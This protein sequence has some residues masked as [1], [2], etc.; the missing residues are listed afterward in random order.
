MFLDNFSR[1][2]RSPSLVIPAKAGIQWG[3][4]GL[5]S[6][7]KHAGMTNEESKM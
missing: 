7:Q 1:H 2:S 4:A 3:G 5:D 6:G